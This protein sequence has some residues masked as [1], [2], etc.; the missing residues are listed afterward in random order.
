VKNLQITGFVNASAAINNAGAVKTKGAEFD[1]DYRTPL[2]G[3]SGNG[4]IS[5][6]DAKF[7]SFK[8]ATC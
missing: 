8:S 6:N 1:F 7:T 4:A 2:E 5:Y 3:L